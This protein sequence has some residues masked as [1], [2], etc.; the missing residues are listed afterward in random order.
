MKRLS[1]FLIF[2]M[3]SQEALA[4]SVLVVLEYRHKNSLTSETTHFADRLR[5]EFRRRYG[6]AALSTDETRSLVSYYKEGVLREGQEISSELLEEGKKAYF[7][8]QLLEA[9]ENLSKLVKKE[10]EITQVEGYV[11]M[12]LTHFAQKRHKVAEDDFS[13][14]LRLDPERSL[15][16]RF[17][18]PK[19]VKFFNR[20]QEQ[21]EKSGSE[22]RVEAD[23]QGAEVWINGV[24]KGLTPLVLSDFPAGRHRLRVR[25]NHFHDFFK[26]INLVKNKSVIFQTKLAWNPQKKEN[27]IGFSSGEI[28]GEGKLVPVISTLGREL[29]AAG[30]LLVSVER[31]QGTPIVRTQLIDV[32]LKTSYKTENLSAKNI[33]ERSADLALQ[34]VNRMSSKLDKSLKENP[35]R[36]AANRYQGDIVLIGHHRKPFYK[37][38]LFWG[39]VAAAGAGGGIAA[40]LAGGAAST[41]TLGIVFQ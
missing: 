29:G 25:A 38:P 39:L 7:Q 27:L 9:E 35:D 37:Q 34:V 3:V 16:P 1:I 10:S 8:L 33:Q 2:L 32:A 5:E 20:V 14:A 13:E 17:F 15:D 24:F 41:G 30:V 12:G 19:V 18:P 36:Y 6:S 31:E 40:A 22:I 23:P 21:Q 11:V 4:G 26:E 28:G